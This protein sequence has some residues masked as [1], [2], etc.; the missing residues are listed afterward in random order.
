MKKNNFAFSFIELIIVITLLMILI[1]IWF[2][3][4]IVYL[5][6]SRDT[7]RISELT[8]I[9]KSM[10]AY[11]SIW[12]LLKPENPVNLYWVNSSNP[13]WFQW[14]LWENLLNR[15]WYNELWK[16]PLDNVYYTYQLRNDLKTFQLA[17][18]LERSPGNNIQSSIFPQVAAA[19]YSDRF[20]RVFGKELGIL[21]FTDNRPIQED[22]SLVSWW[23][24]V[25]TTSTNYK[26]VI[27]NNFTLIGNKD[28]LAFLEFG[29]WK[30]C[31]EILLKIPSLKYSSW[32]YSIYSWS[33]N[34]SVNINCIF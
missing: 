4:Y 17:T 11:K 8:N 27:S 12:P 29:A 5:S 7:S 3:S 18:F 31:E 2:I 6:D 25:S 30:S 21:L 32:T 19:D 1:S 14:Y 10:E 22:S 13:Y 20:P 24:N 28:I 33:L 26:A 16:D 15:I 9:Y 34:K 23:V